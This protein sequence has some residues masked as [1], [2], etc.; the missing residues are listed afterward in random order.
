MNSTARNVL[1]VLG[2][3]V[4][5]SAVNM[6]I[7]MLSGSIIPPPEGADVTTTEGLTASMHLFE[8]RHFIMPFLAHAFGTFMGALVAALLAASQPMRLALG[9]G[10]VFMVGGVSSIFMLPS[11]LWFSVLDVVGAYFP[12]AYAA[13]VLVAGMR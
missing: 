8:P 10:V 4:V 13:G 1:A 12:M 7:I 9:V 3:L 2:G 11:P 5:G 6:G